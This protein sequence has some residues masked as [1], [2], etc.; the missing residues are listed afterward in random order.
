MAYGEAAR[1]VFGDVVV[2]K[3]AA[4]AA[5]DTQQFLASSDYLAAAFSAAHFVRLTGRKDWTA[6]DEQRMAADL[7]EE[8]K[9][10]L[11]AGHDAGAAGRAASLQM[12][13]GESPW[14]EEEMER[15]RKA[16]GEVPAESHAYASVA[17]ADQMADYLILG[18][19]LFW[20]ADEFHEMRTAVIVD[21]EHC[22]RQGADVLAADR[23]AIFDVLEAGLEALTTA[24][25]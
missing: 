21:F 15:L 13:T 6:E 17:V 4:A 3:F 11:Q 20:S 22:V 16:L 24:P 19:P 23:L 10:G 9:L 5:S 1:Q 7:T 18:G 12:L 2:T 8:A 25:G 14:T